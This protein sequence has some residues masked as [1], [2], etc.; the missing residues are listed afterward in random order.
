MFKYSEKN[1][2]FPVA[3]CSFGAMHTVIELLFILRGRDVAERIAR[4]AEAVVA[5]VENNLSRHIPS[6][7]LSVL[8]AAPG[9]TAVP[10]ELYFV[11]ELC[12]RMREGTSGYFDIAAL[13]GCII[14]P[15]Y[16]CT[17]ASHTVR[18]TS[19]EVIVDMGGFAK[20]YALEKVRKMMDGYG[21]ERALLNFGDSSVAAVGAHPYGECWR[22]SP[23][24]R[25]E[26]SFDLK[27]SA[28][29]ISGCGAD[30]HIVDPVGGGKVTGRRDVAVTG[31]SALLCEVLSTALVAAPEGMRGHVMKNFEGYKYTEI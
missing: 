1:E 7:P 20:G 26:L 6:S 5:D 28:L 18:R 30:G 17:P 23:Y 10:D 13:S 4:E 25:K 12:E 27:D 31:R 15:A 22:V 2:E 16:R 29:S 14:R 24:R 19:G 11:L 3:C 9:D 8:N 21:V